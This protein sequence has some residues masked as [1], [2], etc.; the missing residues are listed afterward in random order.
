MLGDGF[1]SARH[2]LLPARFREVYLA[3]MDFG[4]TGLDVFFNGLAARDLNA[5]LDNGFGE[6]EALLIAT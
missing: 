4:E 1:Q 5:K 6:P 3:G 2:E